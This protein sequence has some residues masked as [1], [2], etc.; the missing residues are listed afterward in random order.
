MFQTLKVQGV[1][2]ISGGRDP[3]N[4]LFY[5]NFT[6][7]AG[8]GAENCVRIA[9][10]CPLRLLPI[11]GPTTHSVGWYQECRLQRERN[12]Q[13]LDAVSGPRTYYEHKTDYDLWHPRLAHINPRL[14]LLAKPDL[15]EWPRKAHCDDCAR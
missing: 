4:R 10:G 7:P 6:D 11:T 3:Q 14:A 12:P 1:P 15:K 5:M 13:S 8:V 2:V 9:A